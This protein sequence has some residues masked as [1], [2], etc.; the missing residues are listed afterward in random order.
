MQLSSIWIVDFGSQYTQ[1]IT[2]KTRELG[3]SSKIITLEETKKRF[4][5]Q[6]LPKVLILSGG[7]Q[8][9]FEDPTDYSFLFQH[10]SL[11]ILGICYGMQILGKYFG[12]QVEKGILGE[13]GRAQVFFR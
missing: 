10:A 1:L 12:G 6:S 13:Y 4:S 5:E 7:P 11:P 9:I 8:S 2:R 3:Y